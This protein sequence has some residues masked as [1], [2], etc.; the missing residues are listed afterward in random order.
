MHEFALANELLSLVVESARQHQLSRINSVR[1]G[2]GPIAAI[3]QSI[4]QEL[5]EELSEQSGLGRVRVDFRKLP[6]RLKC[7]F[8]GET[9]EISVPARGFRDIYH[10]PLGAPVPSRCPRCGSS[11][12]SFPEATAVVLEEI[13]AQQ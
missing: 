12:I 9:S 3:N 1:I 4:F 11:E 8:C 13:E 6:L 7:A 5:F 2:L 10:N